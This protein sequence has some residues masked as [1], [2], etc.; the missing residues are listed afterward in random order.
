MP[1]IVALALC[2]GCQNDH[3]DHDSS[4][5]QPMAKEKDAG[6][7]PTA[8]ALIRPAGAAA[9]Q[10]A[11]GNVTGTAKFTQTGDQTVVMVVD[12]KGLKPSS[13]HGIHIHEKGDLT[14]PDLKTAGAHYDPAMTKTH[15]G[16]D[17]AKHHGGDAGNLTA[18]DKGNAHY[19]LTIE[20][21]SLTGKNSIIGRSV[22]IHEKEDD[23]Q[24]TDPSGHS[25]ARIAGGVIEKSSS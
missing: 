4:G 2:A 22:I 14:G 6:N 20:G 11:M 15:G 23:L 12:V 13:K 7:Q 24:N 21:I 9:T 16:P 1:F 5:S 8:T 17:S 18:D 3:K 19:E 10:P 25:G